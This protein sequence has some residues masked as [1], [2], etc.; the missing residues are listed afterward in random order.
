MP[1]DTVEPSVA[2]TMKLVVTKRFWSFARLER[3]CKETK[4]FTNY[5]FSKASSKLD[6]LFG[7]VTENNAW[8]RARLFS[9][10]GASRC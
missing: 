8:M 6:Q 1:R 10:L 4:T 2:S 7:D 5:F 3:R 9:L